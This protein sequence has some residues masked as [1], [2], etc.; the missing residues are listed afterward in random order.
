MG[1]ICPVLRTLF[2]CQSYLVVREVLLLGYRG[3]V[4][5]DMVSVATSPS[6][7]ANLSTFGSNPASF[8]LRPQ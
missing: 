8:F 3:L 6:P 1:R 2:P 5:S 7:F 4:S